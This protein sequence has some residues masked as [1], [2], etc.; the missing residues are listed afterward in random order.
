MSSSMPCVRTRSRAV[1]RAEGSSIRDLYQLQTLLRR[2]KLWVY[3]REGV[4]DGAGDNEVAVP[5]LVGRH[6]VPG[7][8]FGRAVRDGVPES[9]LVVVP[10]GALLDVGRGELP[11]LVRVFETGLE[12]PF[13]LVFG[14]VQEE[15]Q[16]AYA[17]VREVAFEV[18]DLVVALPPD[19][20]GHEVFYPHDEHVLVVGSVEDT[21]PTP[22]RRALVI[23]P[24][25]IVVGFFGTRGLE[26]GHPAPLGIDAAEDVLDGAVF[27]PGVHG[28]Q[29]DEQPPLVLRV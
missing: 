25:K 23:P 24:Q 27:A 21:D 4:G 5:L 17:V 12:S 11:A 13:L 20:V 6:D 28:L 18:V 19:L 16:D 14:D 2:R 22:R 1:G 26:G 29:H 8:V 10:E 15:L 7:S 3:R 9:G